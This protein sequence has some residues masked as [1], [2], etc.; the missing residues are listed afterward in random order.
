MESAEKRSP[1]S[2]A[3]PGADR[4]KLSIN[5]PVKE[6]RSQSTDVCS[7]APGRTRRGKPRHRWTL[8]LSVCS[9]W[10]EQ[11]KVVVARAVVHHIRA[12][13]SRTFL[14]RTVREVTAVVPP[15]PNRAV[16][17]LVDLPPSRDPEECILSPL[18]HRNTLMMMIFHFKFYSQSNIIDYTNSRG[19]R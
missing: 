10:V 17:V 5:T 19:F 8:S 7:R 12:R 18:L 9:Y 14:L 3:W 6:S 13:V 2:T 15:I 16:A 4:Q 11:E 1:S